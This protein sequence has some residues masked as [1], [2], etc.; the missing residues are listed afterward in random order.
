MHLPSD[1]L[2]RVRLL[3]AFAPAFCS[4]DKMYYGTRQA[5]LTVLERLDCY[6]N[7][8][9]PV[10]VLGSRQISLGDLNNTFENLWG[11]NYFLKA[12][13]IKATLIYTQDGGRCVK[14][15]M[16][17]ITFVSELLPTQPLPIDA[18][19]CWGLPIFVQMGVWMASLLYYRERTFDTKEDLRLD[20]ANPAPID[21]NGFW[22]DIFADG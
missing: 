10:Q 13:E 21:F 18:G 5:I 9:E 2:Y 4:F 8:P 15:S 19:E 16:R 12:E 6:S 20:M 22:Q 14:A 17:G 11:Y 3:D 7:E 1:Q